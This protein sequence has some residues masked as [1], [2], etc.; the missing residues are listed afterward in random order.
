MLYARY[1]RFK[2]G[3]QFVD[4]F[5]LHT[6]PWG[7]FVARA[8]RAIGM[9]ELPSPLVNQTYSTFIENLGYSAEATRAALVPYDRDTEAKIIKAITARAAVVPATPPAAAAAPTNSKVVAR[10]HTPNAA[11]P[12]APSAARPAAARPNGRG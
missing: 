10:P 12:H 6:K 5:E 2:Q 4:N 8:R 9:P 3:Q 7:K 1:D 11:K